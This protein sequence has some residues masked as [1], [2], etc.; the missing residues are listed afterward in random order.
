MLDGND[1]FGST[2]DLPRKKLAAQRPG[3]RATLQ[4][5]AFRLIVSY[6]REAPIQTAQSAVNKLENL[7]GSVLPS[8]PVSNEERESTSARLHWFL[9]ALVR[10]E[11]DLAPTAPDRAALAGRLVGAAVGRGKDVLHGDSGSLRGGVVSSTTSS[12]VAATVM[13]TSGANGADPP[14]SYTHLTLPTILLV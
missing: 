3:Q 1:D 10:A 7:L 4:R 8:A 9:A 11:S 5:V 2:E 12:A 13:T 14:I 6:I